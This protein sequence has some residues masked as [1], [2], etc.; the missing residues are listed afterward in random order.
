[1]AKKTN[2]NEVPTSVDWKGDLVINSGIIG[3][4]VYD[5]D[6]L[7]TLSD[8][9]PSASSDLTVN[10]VSS[11]TVSAQTLT[12]DSLT[13][14]TQ[15][16][17]D[18]STA[19]TVNVL[20]VDSNGVIKKKAKSNVKIYRALITQTSTNTPVATILENT[21]TGTPT[22]SRTGAGNYTI[23]LTGQFTAGKTI[24]NGITSFQ[25]NSRKVEY[26]ADNS[27]NYWYVDLDS[28][29]APNSIDLY[30]TGPYTN[31]STSQTVGP[32]E[33]STALGATPYYLEIISYS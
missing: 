9:I 25:G 17:T 7:Y 19:S 18:T 23:T 16:T 11:P 8:N 13:I 27:G 21:F 29:N 14:A 32:V 3:E 15:P 5:I 2:V 12:T 4:I 30:I 6:E 1:M 24:A 22:W 28:W 26:F 10:S 33:M 20:T 31:L